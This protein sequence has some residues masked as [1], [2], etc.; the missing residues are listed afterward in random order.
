MPL[1]LFKTH[2]ALAFDFPLGN[3]IFSVCCIHKWQEMKNSTVSI[4]K[5]IFLQR[6]VFALS[7]QE[8]DIKS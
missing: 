2:W 3:T 1:I 6:D 4:F 7:F 5:K 8:A